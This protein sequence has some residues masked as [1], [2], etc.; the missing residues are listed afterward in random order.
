M[1]QNVRQW[2]GVLI[3]AFALGCS[4]GGSPNTPENTG[5]STTEDG[6]TSNARTRVYA[7]I[8]SHNEQDVNAKCQPVLNEEARWHE[9]RSLTL[10]FASAIVESGGAYD[11]Q[12]DFRWLEQMQAWETEA[13]RAETDGDN[14]LAYLASAFPGQVV[15]DAHNHDTSHNYADVAYLLRES[16]VPDTR[17]VGGHV[18]YPVESAD[19]ERFR[20][21]LPGIAHDT[22]WSPAILWGGATL[23]HAGPDSEASGVWRPR[24]AVDY[25]EDDP[26]G[27]LIVM[28]NFVDA[29]FEIGQGGGIQ[30]LLDELRAG[31]HPEGVMLTVS[32]FFDQCGLTEEDV[33]QV[34]A[35]IEK[36][37]SDVEAGDLVWATVP[38]LIAAWETDYGARAYIA[39]AP[40]ELEGCGDC[41]PEEVCCR[42]PAP[43][44]GTC[45]PRCQDSAQ[46]CPPGTNCQAN[47]HCE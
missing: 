21:P 4:D 20:D 45:V 10:A 32:V 19:W 15:V 14:L 30:I 1:R 46:S 13:E 41:D 5:D 27:T 25:H 31:N 3:A 2:L 36:H 24:S 34:V 8:V 6:A 23:Q 18:W 29:K 17:V 43:C 16:G 9:N 11:L 33:A 39:H 35:L 28:G 44:A 38:D 47:G 40:T 37:K 26:E 42:A 22:L 7:V 12:T